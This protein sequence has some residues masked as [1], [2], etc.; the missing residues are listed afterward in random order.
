MSELETHLQAKIALAQM[1]FSMV[2]H[3]IQTP[4]GIALCEF[5]ET[6]I[7]VS[8]PDGKHPDGFVSYKEPAR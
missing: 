5:M 6:G 8:Y 3:C 7:K 1:G 2:P 4:N